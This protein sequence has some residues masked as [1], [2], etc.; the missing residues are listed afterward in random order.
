MSK[1]SSVESPSQSSSTPIKPALQAVLGCLDVNLEAELTTYRRHRRRAEQWVSPSVRSGQ[2]TATTEPQKSQNLPQAAEEAQQPLS[3]P[4]SLG[5]VQGDSPLAT[6]V[7]GTKISSNTFA[8]NN[9]LESSE[10]LIESLDAAKAEPAQERSLAAS[11]LTPLGLSSMLLF[12]LSCTALG[13]AVMHPS[14]LVKMAGLNR[15]LDRTTPSTNESPAATT[16][17]SSSSSKELP[18]APNLASKEFVEL[19]LNTLSNV[20]PTTSPIASPSPK[21]SIPPNPPAPPAPI[22]AVPIPTEDGNPARGREQGLNNISTALLP[23][24]SPSATQTVPTLPTLPPTPSPAQPA[25]ASP[26]TAAPT[27]TAAPAAAAPLGRPTRASDGFY[28]VVTDYTNEKALQQARTAVPDAY[29]R[30]F[31][32]GVKI[33]MGALND[34]AS[35]ERL[36]KELQ[37]KGMKPQYYQP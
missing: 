3:L 33:Q 13:Y 15:F 21:A 32:K 23:S 5:G 4:L 10:K 1:R 17:D 14:S 27:A 18:K 22:G 30:N 7:G 24:P 8:P 36:A 20:N 25:A 11:L 19:D 37:A 12:L 35:A 31:S 29:V 2:P 6:T 28:Y 9:Y 16:I 26:A 34:A